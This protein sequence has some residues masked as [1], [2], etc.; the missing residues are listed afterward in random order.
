MR[1]TAITDTESAEQHKAGTSAREDTPKVWIGCLAAYN[2]GELHGR[3]V[4]ATD[5]DELESARVHVIRT[6]PVWKSGG[7]AEEHAVMDYD[8]FGSLSAALGE[9][10]DFK[11]LAVVGEAIEKHGEVFIAYVEACEPTLNDEVASGFDDAYRGEWD[12][13]NAYAEDFIS[14]CGF[15]GV[16]QI[17]D[18]LLPY[19]DMDMIAREIF[20]HGPMIS[21]PSASGRVHVFDT[22]A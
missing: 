9:W 19:L 20:R 14:E 11:T 1:R 17:P 22:E 2:A 15:A 13:E 5:L 3:W 8:G 4:Q 7:M 21:R 18:E 16:Q 12:S 10:P 6:S